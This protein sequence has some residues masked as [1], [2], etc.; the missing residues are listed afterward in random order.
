MLVTQEYG[1]EPPLQSKDR[2]KHLLRRSETFRTR[3][4]TRGV[5]PGLKKEGTFEQFR[6]FVFL[7]EPLDVF[8]GTYS[9]RDCIKIIP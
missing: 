2:A 3:V 6:G 5:V 7:E 1:R 4:R 9:Y 8:L